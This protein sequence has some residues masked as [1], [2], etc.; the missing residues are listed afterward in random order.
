MHDMPS[1]APFLL[2]FAVPDKD[3][4]K[5][6]IN[7]NKPG[8]CFLN[9]IVLRGGG[10]AGDRHAGVVGHRLSFHRSSKDNPT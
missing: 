7:K 8:F 9:G 5:K 3:A 6:T 4:A 2:F 1:I 10:G